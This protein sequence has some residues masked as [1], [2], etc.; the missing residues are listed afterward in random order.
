M[1]RVLNAEYGPELT[2]SNAAELS[3]SACAMSTCWESSPGL[4]S[5]FI[6]L[7]IPATVPTNSAS[8]SYTHLTLPTICSV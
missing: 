8:V 7:W 1:K 3:F 6:P 2:I 4:N 5:R